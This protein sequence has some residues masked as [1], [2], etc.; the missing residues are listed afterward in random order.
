MVTKKRYVA[1][2]YNFVL[3]VTS[4]LVLGTEFVIFVNFGKL[5]SNKNW[6]VHGNVTKSCTSVLPRH[7]NRVLTINTYPSYA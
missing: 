1:V 3:V 7:L 2:K 5:K 6:T 4:T